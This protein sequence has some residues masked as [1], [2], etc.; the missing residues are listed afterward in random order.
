[1]DTPKSA[2]R[3]QFFRAG[4]V[5]S[6][7]LAAQPLLFNILSCA[8][9]PKK[10]LLAKIIKGLDSVDPLVQAHSAILLGELKA[11]EALG[12][13]VKY[14]K[15]CRY[16]AK[17][18][19]FNALMEIGDRGVL[20]DI[21][22]LIEKPNVPIDDHWYHSVCVQSAAA[23]ANIVLGGN[24]GGRFF[25]QIANTE[26]IKWKADI[27]YL[28]YSPFILQLPDTNS[29][30]AAL[31]QQTKKLVL[32]KKFF[33]PERLTVAAR[34]LGVLKGKKAADQ[35]RWHITNF[36]SRY[37]RGNGAYNLLIAESSQEN[38][39]MLDDL[40]NNDITDFVKIQAAA[41]LHLSGKA[42]Y[43]AYIVDRAKNASDTIDCTA[44][45]EAL[46]LKPSG[47]G[48]AV[49]MENVQHEIPYI[50]LCAIEALEKHKE[51]A[52]RKIAGMAAKDPDPRVQ[53]QATKFM[54]VKE[55]GV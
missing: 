29:A 10:V 35:L 34:A 41:A 4:A 2:T 9:G 17:S 39:A 11:K 28:W 42:G 27:F 21:T 5:G 46:G 48:K 13:L 52:N 16:Y 45:M 14:V 8:G 12:P 18:A 47:A 23:L 7:L 53:L 55:G 51:P 3:R 22:P 44:A 1:M 25:E 32:M 19:G 26:T 40:F 15:E 49:L 37:I 31:K 6:V 54:I 24:D 43:E 36:Q 38:A 50:R 30:I 33:Q 20:A